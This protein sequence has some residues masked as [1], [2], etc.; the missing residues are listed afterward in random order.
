[1]IS[2]AVPG[3]LTLP[4]GG[5]AY[6]RRVLA[7]WDALGIA[8]DVIPLAE[9]FPFPSDEALLEA[10]A[11]LSGPGPYLID[12]MAYGAFTEDMAARIG[13]KSVALVHHPLCDEQGLDAETAT[14]LKDRERA[15]LRHAA[16]VL[17]TSPLT[18]RDLARRFDVS[19]S[20]IAIPGTDPA[21][22]APLSG[23]PPC[24]LSVGAVTPR[25]GYVLLV[26][27]LSACRDLDWVCEIVGADDR[28]DAEVAR[29]HA[30]IAEAGLADRIAVRG[31]IDDMSAAYIGADLFVSS[32]LHEGYGM[33]VVEAMAHGL[34]VVT[35]TGGA[36]GETA[37]VARLVAPGDVPALAEA[38]RSVLIDADARRALAEECRT[39]A[40]GLPAWPE[41]A[42]IIARAVD[43]LR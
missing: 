15:A 31:E 36:L 18:A 20:A 42:Q 40:T 7:E 41:T 8:A 3:D 17:V 19:E 21:P 38:L 34:P 29:V 10:D 23:K 1:M 9:S 11:A 2:F 28:D 14:F 33:A 37:P 26:E 25:K 13:P 35:T 32:S 24:V 27:A 6:T 16:G 43:Q 39:F 12:G 30:A 5:Y 22:Q 4:T